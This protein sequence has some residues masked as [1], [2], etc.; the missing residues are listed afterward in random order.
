VLLA[1]MGAAV[2]ATSARIGLTDR[3]FTRVGAADD[4][5]R[6]QSTFFVEMAETAN[7]LHNATERSLVILDE[8][9][10]GTST[11]DGVSLAWA[12]TEHLHH[13]VQARALFATHYHELAEL[14]FILDRAKNFNVAVRDWGG[15]IVFLRKIVP[16]GCDRSYG[17]HVARLAGIPGP[18]I[19]RAREILAGLEAQAADRDA[20]YLKQGEVLRAA[21]RE[22]QLDLFAPARNAAAD[23]FRAS[24]AAIDPESLSPREAHERLRD[25]I[26]QA[27]TPAP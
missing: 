26:E 10:R 21:A 19:E 12:V 8:V 16:G 13:R 22:V 9:G 11:F 2:P 27:R 1:Q 25:L 4:L 23:A 6:G 24:V 5:A 18:V 15:E 14:G 20:S 3:I 17:I 7:I